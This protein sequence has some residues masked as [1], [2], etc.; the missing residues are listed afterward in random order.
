MSSEKGS[1]VCTAKLTAARFSASRAVSGAR[2]CSFSGLELVR[3]DDPE[4]SGNSGFHLTLPGWAVTSGAPVL[5]LD[6]AP[7]FGFQAHSL[8]DRDLFSKK[9]L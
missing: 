9:S 1:P 6:A 3:E 8:A 5:P 4:V 2:F 7:K